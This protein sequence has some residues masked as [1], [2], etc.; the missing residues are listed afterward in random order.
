[1]LPLQVGEGVDDVLEAVHVVAVDVPVP[2]VAI[3]L[4]AHVPDLLGH[5]PPRGRR[6]LLRGDAALEHRD[7]QFAQYLETREREKGQ[8]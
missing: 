7:L 2:Q 1:M 5:D 4:V 3:G 8:I 6:D